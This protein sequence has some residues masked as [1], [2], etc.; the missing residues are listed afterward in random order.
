MTRFSAALLSVLLLSAAPAGAQEVKPVPQTAAKKEPVKKPEAKKAAA[1]KQE[2]APAPQP[3]EA[4][5]E[6][7]VFPPAP[8]LDEGAPFAPYPANA[9]TTMGRERTWTTGEE[10][11]LLDVARHFNLGYV[12]MRAANPEIDAWAPAPDTP[13]LI[14]TFRILPRARQDGIVVN[15]AKMRLYYFR[16]PGAEPVT[17]PIGIGR[18]G[19]MTPLGDTVITHKVAYPTWRP[20]PRMRAEH[21]YLPESVPPGPMNPLG[22]HALYLGWPEFRIHG[23]NKPWAIG[24]RVS[25]GC[26]RMYPEDIIRLFEMVPDGTKVT[27]VEQPLLLAWKGRTLWFEANPS[28]RQSNQIEIDGEFEPKP[29]TDAVR[30]AIAAAA[31]PAGKGRIDW[32]AVEKAMLER[33]GV[34]VIIA[35]LDAEKEAVK[36]PE[37]EKKAKPVYRYND[38]RSK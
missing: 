23:S 8:D 31:G 24:R 18:D 12:E 15:L 1:K 28:R 6:N 26:V 4:S 3:D 17:F 32:A 35:D 22:T 5:D 37:P 2:A 33:K 19:L 9:R 36:A 7:A 27:V 20:T 21:S 29:S 30:A 13:M 16:T 38:Q 11:T 14:P 25:S 10:D 34:P